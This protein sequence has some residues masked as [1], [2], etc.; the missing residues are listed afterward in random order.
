MLILQY[1]APLLKYL[2]SVVEAGRILVDP[3]TRKDNATKAS[4][5][6]AKVGI[7]AA[8]VLFIDPNTP[9]DVAII[10]LIASLGLYFYRRQMQEK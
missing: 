1:L 4:T 3:E 7:G 2:P 5:S 9:P 6:I 10:T 8:G